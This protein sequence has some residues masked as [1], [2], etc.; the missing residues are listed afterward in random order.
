[1]T[2]ATVIAQTTFKQ[3][4]LERSLPMIRLGCLLSVVAALAFQQADTVYLAPEIA[5]DFVKLRHY[6]FIP[7]LILWSLITFLPWKRNIHAWIF[8]TGL[9]I[10]L[11]FIF[12]GYLT[13]RYSD[14]HSAEA[15][16]F[17]NPEIVDTHPIGIYYAGI[18][19]S[20]ICYFALALFNLPLRFALSF[21]VITLGALGIVIVELQLTPPQVILAASPAV[22][23]SLLGLITGIRADIREW[24]A[25]KRIKKLQDESATRL[26]LFSDRIKVL[27]HELRTQAAFVDAK[28]HLLRPSLTSE[29][30]LELLDSASRHNDLYDEV[31]KAATEASTLEDSLMS[32]SEEVDVVAVLRQMLDDYKSQYPDYVFEENMSTRRAVMQDRRQFTQMMQNLINNAI[33]HAEPKSSIRIRVDDTDEQVVFSVANDGSALPEDTSELFELYHS[34][35]TEEKDHIGFGLYAVK[36]IAESMGGSVSAV[37]NQDPEG[38]TFI[39]SLP[40]LSK[41]NA[42]RLRFAR[43][44]ERFIGT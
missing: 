26:R 12:A 28:L 31:I 40:Y 44:F 15:L 13:E 36:V 6:Y 1:M 37:N 33:Q 22:A 11:S 5:A 10:G 30:D 29:K 25:Y 21:V 27:K 8:F 42:M 17:A 35:Q 19:L 9:P 41:S 23:I 14:I 7:I 4:R 16:F 18:A 38:A 2:D 39:V 3:Y 24:R 43:T 34:T 20:Q 32:P